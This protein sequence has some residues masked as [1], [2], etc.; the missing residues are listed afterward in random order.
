M[1][2]HIRFVKKS[3]IRKAIIKNVDN[4]KLLKINWWGDYLFDMYKQIVY[5]ST[6]NWII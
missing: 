1:S 6:T 3:K 2:N 4:K 5:L